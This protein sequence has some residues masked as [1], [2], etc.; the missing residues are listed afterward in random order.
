M[1]LGSDTQNGIASST[2]AL[3]NEAHVTLA[4]V[5]SIV[6]VQSVILVLSRVDLEHEG[7]LDAVQAIDHWMR[8]HLRMSRL[9]E[10]S[11]R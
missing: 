10:G 3:I 8:G 1:H 6:G 4:F 9:T 7:G 5:G 2:R 11:G